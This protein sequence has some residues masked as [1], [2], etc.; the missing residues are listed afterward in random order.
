MR[1][2]SHQTMKKQTLS[3]RSSTFH[4][5]TQLRDGKA[6]RPETVGRLLL[7]LR[8]TPTNNSKRT[9]LFSQSVNNG[10]VEPAGNRRPA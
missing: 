10:D 7:V 6:G 4:T 9:S 5:W 8:V 3:K 1:D 2:R